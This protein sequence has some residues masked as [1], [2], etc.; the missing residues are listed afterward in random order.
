MR[1]G[2]RFV[3]LRLS[4][5]AERTHHAADS[6]GRAKLVDAADLLRERAVEAPAAAAAEIGVRGR[7]GSGKKIGAGGVSECAGQIEPR[8]GRLCRGIDVGERR[9]RGR[10]TNAARTEVRNG[11]PVF[12]GYERRAGGVRRE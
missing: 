12:A 10:K 5:A 6:R 2:R 3:R 1:P 11:A 9:I 8:V 4:L 7:H